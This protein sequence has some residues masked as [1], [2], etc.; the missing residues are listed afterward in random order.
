M[1]VH[2]DKDKKDLIDELNM[3]QTLDSDDGGANLVESSTFG[4]FNQTSQKDM[5][6][7]EHS[8]VGHS[9]TQSQDF[10]EKFD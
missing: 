5:S 7:R 3:N 4:G 6:T 9:G 2:E 10:F 1:I 8:Y